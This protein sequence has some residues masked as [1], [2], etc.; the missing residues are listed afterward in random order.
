MTF[1]VNV[2]G[3]PTPTLQWY[4]NGVKI[5]EDY[6]TENCQDGTLLIPSSE[7]RHSGVYK[8]VAENLC[9][10]D[11]KEVNPIILDETHHFQLCSFW[12]L[13]CNLKLRQSFYLQP[14]LSLCFHFKLIHDMSF[15][16][17]IIYLHLLCLLKML[18]YLN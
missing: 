1:K 14:I 9:G 2:S 10:I 12:N 8:L 15:H 16:Q 5:A 18:A 13:S 7:K 17:W 6:S 3:Y 11:E 4:F